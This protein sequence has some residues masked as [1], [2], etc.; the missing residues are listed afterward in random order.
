MC[1]AARLSAIQ[2]KSVE[3]QEQTLSAKRAGAAEVVVCCLLFVVVVVAA[4]GVVVAPDASEQ[5]G[6][7]AC[8]AEKLLRSVEATLLRSVAAEESAASWTQQKAQQQ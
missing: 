2:T 1:R 7:S 3:A 5:T 6:R 8:W 4:A